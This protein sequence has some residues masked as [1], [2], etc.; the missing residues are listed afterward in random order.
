MATN[1]KEGLTVNAECLVGFTFA[2][3]VSDFT[4]DGGIVEL[5]A[6]A[7]DGQLSRVI[8]LGYLVVDEPLVNNVGRVGIG[9]TRQANRFRFGHPFLFNRHRHFWRVLDFH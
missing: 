8:T 6:G 2:D 1:D 5:A 7:V 9:V 4:F 3:C